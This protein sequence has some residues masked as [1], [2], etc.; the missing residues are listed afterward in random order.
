MAP[1][2]G[3]QCSSESIHPSALIASTTLGLLA[4]VAV[5]LLPVDPARGEVGRTTAV[6][7]AARGTPPESAT[8]VLIP[9]LDVF[10]NERIETGAA[11]ITQILFRDGSN[12]T[13]G[14]N[15]DLVIDRFVFDPETSAGELAA[16]LGRGVLRFVGGQLSKRGAVRVTTPVAVIG[17]RGGIAV[18]NHDQT[19]KGTHATFLFGA[20]MTVRGVGE[21]AVSTRLTRPGFAVSVSGEG[22]IGAPALV[23]PAQLNRTLATFEGSGDSDGGAPVRPSN[24]AVRRSAYVQESATPSA[25]GPESLFLAAESE[26]VAP[27][28]AAEIRTETVPGSPEEEQPQIISPPVSPAALWRYALDASGFGGDESSSFQAC[29]LPATA[30]SSSRSRSSSRKA[31]SAKDLKPAGDSSSMSPT[32]SPARATAKSVRCTSTSALCST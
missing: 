25:A 30:S 7:P 1:P 23:T 21:A 10:A 14:P 6:Q 26:T 4:M 2:S 12:I 27:G 22:K 17:V 5:T 13:V 3:Q 28:T 15:S 9:K 20:E 29:R 18:I 11:G 19:D 24:E 16:T 8:R 31:T 32:V